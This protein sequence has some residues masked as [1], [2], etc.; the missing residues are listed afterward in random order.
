MEDGTVWWYIYAYN[1]VKIMLLILRNSCLMTDWDW[2]LVSR[3]KHINL[4]STVHILKQQTILAMT[5]WININNL[6]EYCDG[7]A[8]LVVLT[9]YWKFRSSLI[10]VLFLERG[11]WEMLKISLSNL[12]IIWYQRWQW[13]TVVPKLNR[14]NFINLTV[15]IFSSIFKNEFLQIDHQSRGYL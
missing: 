12:I 14:E 3:S 9:Y 1:Y 8:N 11:I 7:C 4:I 15:N 2:L 6:L 10:F 5:W 13:T